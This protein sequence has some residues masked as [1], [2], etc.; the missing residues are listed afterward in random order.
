ML[1]GVS[2]TKTELCFSAGLTQSHK[3]RWH[4]LRL[5]VNIAAAPRSFPVRAASITNL[6][7]AFS[8]HYIKESFEKFKSSCSKQSLSSKSGWAHPCWLKS[9]SEES[10]LM[11]KLVWLKSLSE[12]AAEWRSSYSFFRLS[13]SVQFESK[14][15]TTTS[16]PP[17]LSQSLSERQQ[18][19]LSTWRHHTLTSSHFRLKTASSKQE[20]TAPG[21]ELWGVGECL[22]I[23]RQ[24]GRS[25][26]PAGPGGCRAVGA[27]GPVLAPPGTQGHGG[28]W[29]RDSVWSCSCGPLLH[30]P[31]AVGR[32]KAV[33][34]LHLT[35]L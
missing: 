5:Q 27:A 4:S 34:T 7:K 8:K 29:F 26:R 14:D 24:T 1:A 21:S 15:R 18:L 28:S 13:V 12:S 6:P 17:F 16:H 2:K 19:S 25:N 9:L 3:Y 11:I 32:N 33:T 30:L 23:C 22:I 20:G 31:G 10:T 35:S